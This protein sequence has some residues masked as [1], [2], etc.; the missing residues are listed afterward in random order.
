MKPDYL[1]FNENYVPGKYYYVVPDGRS[2]EQVFTKFWTSM[3]RRVSRLE[4]L[5][6]GKIMIYKRLKYR[7]RKFTPEN[8]WVSTYKIVEVGTKD[9]TTHLPE[10]KIYQIF[11]FS[12]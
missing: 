6:N 5:E 1:N 10:G 9:R 12:E 11:P 3:D 2:F 4:F 8:T 7:K